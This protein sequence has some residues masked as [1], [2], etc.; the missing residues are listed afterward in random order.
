MAISIQEMP[1]SREVGFDPPTVVT[2]WVCEGVFSSDTVAALCLSTTPAVASHPF[3][4]LYR[5]DIMVREAG[6]QLYNITV[7]YATR[8]RES[9]S[10]RFEFDTLGGTVHV[11]AGTH[12]N[13]YPAGKPTHSGLIG[14]KGTD[15]EGI[16]VV[17]P[18]MKVVV[19]FKHP[20]GIIT[21]TQIKILSRLS[22]AVDTGGFFGWSAYETLFL[23]AQGS[24][25]TDC[26]TEIAYHFAMS[27]NLVDVAI[28]GV[29]GITKRGWDVA[30]VH[31][32]QAVEAGKAAPAAEYVNV[33]RVYKE[34][35]LAAVLGFG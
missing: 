30:W 9:G 13:V 21:P 22:G 5:Q 17:I 15:V 3:G 27:E 24:E 26:E 25:G 10:Y 16:D 8:K 31:W 23:G 20:A 6:H 29:T 33:V 14:V 4:L 32:Q 34:R 18:A 35:A 28:G 1:E 2:K 19:H 11:T 12:V 7:P